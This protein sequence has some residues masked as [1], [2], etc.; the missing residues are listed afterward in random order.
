[1]SCHQGLSGDTRVVEKTAFSTKAS[2]ISWSSDTQTM[3]SRTFNDSLA[4]RMS[5]WVRRVL[6]FCGGA[7]YDS[8]DDAPVKLLKIVSPCRTCDA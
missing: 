2:S 5:D 7:D 6:T 4:A 3:N 1:M 8:D